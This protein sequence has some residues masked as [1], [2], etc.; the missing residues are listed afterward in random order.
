M[1]R[2][3][4]VAKCA[5]GILSNLAVIGIGLTLYEQKLW[6][7]L[8]IGIGTAAAALFIAWSMNHD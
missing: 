7:V 3:K 1:N 2:W 8:A 4:A 6:P 5:E